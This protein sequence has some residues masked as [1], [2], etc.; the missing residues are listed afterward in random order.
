LE[1]V[2]ELVVDLLVSHE[3]V[4]LEATL[5]EVLLIAPRKVSWR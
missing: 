5:V 2:H 3:I 1:I 4:L